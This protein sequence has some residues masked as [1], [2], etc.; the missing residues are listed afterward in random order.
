MVVFITCKSDEEPIKIKWLSSGQHF[1][2]SMRPSRVGNCHVSSLKRA[3]IEFDRDFMPVLIICKF[4]EVR[5]KMKSLSSVQ[6]FPRYMSMRDYR[7]S[8]SHA[9]SPI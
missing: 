8:I 3:R 4:N 6:C 7:A 5:S 2:K 1:P 9:N